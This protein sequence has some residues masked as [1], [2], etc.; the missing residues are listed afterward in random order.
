[1]L[2]TKLVAAVLVASKIAGV[3]VGAVLQVTPS[4]VPSSATS[5]TIISL[6]AVTAV[7]L[8][9]HVAAEALVAQEKAPEDAD[10]HAATEGLAAV[11][12]AEQLVSVKIAALLSVPKLFAALVPICTIPAAL[13]LTVTSGVTVGLV[14]GAKLNRFVAGSSTPVLLKSA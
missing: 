7:V 11:P 12:T 14:D 8:I 10:P 13:R 2:I 3:T 6:L 5:T 9:V 4:L 1:M